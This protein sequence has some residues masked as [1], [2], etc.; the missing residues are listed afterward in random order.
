MK[1]NNMLIKTKKILTMTTAVCVISSSWYLGVVKAEPGDQSDPLISKSYI[2]EKLGEILNQINDLVGKDRGI[3]RDINSLNVKTKSIES[4]HQ[5]DVKS[6]NQ[7]INNVNNE[8]EDL[9]TNLNNEISIIKT[10]VEKNLEQSFEYEI[11]ELKSGQSLIFNSQSELIVR[12]GVVTSIA[13]RAG[14]LSDLTDGL[15]ISNGVEVLNNHHILVPRG[16][17][18]GIKIESGNAWVMV[19]GKFEIIN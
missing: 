18:R 19:K 9:S 16:D 11:V 3:L 14:G 8:V 2:D 13:S 6:L 17:G 7:Y 12:S 1:N 4:I 5:R 10:E 15:D